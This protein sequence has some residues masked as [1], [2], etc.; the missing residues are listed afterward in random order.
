MAIFPP[1]Y[2][3]ETE[4]EEAAELA[5]ELIKHVGFRISKTLAG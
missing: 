1:F 5:L 4:T 3:R 2:I